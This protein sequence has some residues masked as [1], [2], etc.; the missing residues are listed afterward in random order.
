M[1]NRILNFILLHTLEKPLYQKDIEKEFNI[2]KSTATE[3]LKLME[4]NGFICRE[5]SPKDARLK[6]IIPTKKA[7]AMRQNVMENIRVTEAKLRQGVSEEDYET[8]MRV[9][10]KM[11]DNLGARE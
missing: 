9:L 6:E 3:I 2:R 1:Q 8:F 4:K 5:C 11:S 7:L 10:K